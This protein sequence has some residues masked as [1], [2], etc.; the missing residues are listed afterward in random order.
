VA[1]GQGPVRVGSARRGWP[2]EVL[3]VVA[4]SQ[5]ALKPREVMNRI[6]LPLAYTTMSTVS[7]R[8]HAKGLLTRTYDG[9]CY[10]TALNRTKPPQGR[11]FGWIAL[12]AR[13]EASK[14]A[15]ILV[16]RHQLMVLRCQVSCG[17][18]KPR[19]GC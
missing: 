5:A 1:A 3:A 9:R 2:A 17:V 7:T 6:D 18:R 19:F 12:L 10:A 15:E 4:A 13:S 14:D 16:L 8:L 11:V